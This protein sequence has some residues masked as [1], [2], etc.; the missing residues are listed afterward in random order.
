MVGWGVGVS[1]AVPNA[2]ITGV[3]TST[4]ATYE[5]F[6]TLDVTVSCLAQVGG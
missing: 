5:L 3:Y 1:E 2:C 6:F 4:A